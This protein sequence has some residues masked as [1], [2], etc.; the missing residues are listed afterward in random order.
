MLSLLKY[1]IKNRRMT[2]LGLTI[3]ILLNLVILYKIEP[4]VSP[5]M[6]SKST[7]MILLYFLIATFSFPILIIESIRVLGNDLFG[8][9]GYLLFTLPKSSYKILGA[10]VLTV[11]LGY[12]IWLFINMLFGFLNFYKLASGA[13]IF[14]I[15]LDYFPQFIE[16]ALMWLLS[17]TVSFLVF[18]LTIYFAMTLT[19]SLLVNNKHKFLISSLIF[20]LISYLITKIS[21]FL[22]PNEFLHMQK[23]ANGG[24]ILIPNI[25]IILFDLILGVI[26]FFGSSY[27]LANRINL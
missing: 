2:L 1:E 17:F 12:L 23:L 11:F 22:G 15:F 9:T 16:P 21:N 10:K 6:D 13:D 25:E 19:K 7:A 5:N 4:Q 8:N 18:I 14:A 24:A 26:L 3:I 20:L 27:L